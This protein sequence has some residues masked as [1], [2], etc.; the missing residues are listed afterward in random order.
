MLRPEKTDMLKKFDNIFAVGWTSDEDGETPPKTVQVGEITRTN[1]PDLIYALA[2]G[3][4]TL[5]R[6]LAPQLDVEPDMFI[7]WLN[8][9]LKEAPEDDDE[10]EGVTS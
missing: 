6:G 9:A 2:S 1:A 8:Y 10:P 4:T 7:E 3:I 5:F